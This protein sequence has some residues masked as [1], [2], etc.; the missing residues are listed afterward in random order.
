MYK[1]GNGKRGFGSILA[2]MR[3]LALCNHQTFMLQYMCI[4]V[5]IATLPVK[6]LLLKLLPGHG[7]VTQF[8]SLHSVVK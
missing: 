6:Y 4:D 7:L 8:G 3:L 1:K 5:A 2:K